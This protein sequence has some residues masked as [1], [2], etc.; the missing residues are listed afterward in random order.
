[1]LEH[2]RGGTCC[3]TSCFHCG[4]GTRNGSGD[5]RHRRQLHRSS[6][7]ETRQRRGR[8]QRPRVRAIRG[9]GPGG[10]GVL[11]L[12]GRQGTPYPGFGSRWCLGCSELDSLC[13]ETHE[14]VLSCLRKDRLPRKS[15]S[16]SRLSLKCFLCVTNRALSYSNQDVTRKERCPEVHTH[17]THT[18]PQGLVTQCTFWGADWLMETR[19]VQSDLNFPLNEQRC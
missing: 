11:T 13:P 12:G 17:V 8:C 9:H 3:I 14:A 6:P 2:T 16:G 1:M 4:L 10:D 18:P 5:R 19:G 7:E 15:R